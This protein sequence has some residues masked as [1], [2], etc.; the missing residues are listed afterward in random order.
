MI[1][2]IIPAYNEEAN[3]G[4]LL[5]NISSIMNKHFYEYNII[6]VN[7]GSKDKTQSII[8]SFQRIMPINLINHETNKGVGQVF[9]S[10]FAKALEIM[11]GK[12]DIIVTMEA[13]NTSDINILNNMIDKVSDGYDLVLASCYAKGGGIENTTLFRLILSRGANLFTRF[14]FKLRG[15]NTLTSFYRAYD[16]D[17]IKRAFEAYDGKLIEQPGFACMVEL[18][19]KLMKFN[20]QVA[21]VPMVLKCQMRRDNSKMKVSRTIFEHVM[22]TL[23]YGIFQRKRYIKNNFS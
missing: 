22:L 12:D 7:D 14:L 15:I 11:N 18:L 23:K 1:I 17:L 16:G 6:A 2:F 10:G 5:R 19:I 21:E 20:A 8:E 4:T 9:R 13:D 3:I